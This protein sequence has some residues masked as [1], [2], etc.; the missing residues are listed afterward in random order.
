MTT[1]RRLMWAAFI[2]GLGPPD[3][4]RYGA[5]PVPEPGPTDVLVRVHA[6]AVNPVD[7]MIRSG[8]YRTLVDFPFVIGRDLV[9][10][11]AELGSQVTGFAIGDPVWCNSLGHDGRQGACLLYTSPSPRD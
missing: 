9:G 7:T 10:R 1:T 8:R 11:V 6:V 5:L 4:I 2:D 3:T